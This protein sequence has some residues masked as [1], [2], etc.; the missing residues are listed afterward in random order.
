MIYAGSSP[1]VSLLEYMCIKGNAVGLKSWYMIVFDIT[2][3]NLIG[4]LDKDNL[5]SN[6]NVL[7]HGRSTQ[8]FGKIWLREKKFPFLKVPSARVNIAFYPT[9]HNL[10]INPDFPGFTSLMK[11]VD[12][13][14]PILNWLATALH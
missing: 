13:A 14:F 3:N 2:D 12:S 5:P 8:E 4:T 6:W 11:I 10:L 9:E 7:P 1:A